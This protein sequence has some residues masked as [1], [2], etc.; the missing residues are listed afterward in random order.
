MI[1]KRIVFSCFL[2]VI[3]LT[4]V[5]FV[6]SITVGAFEF[7]TF[8]NEE[9]DALISNIQIETLQSA[10][11]KQ[12]IKCFNVNDSG[13]IA[14][15]TSDFEQKTICIYDPNGEFQYGYRFYTAGSFG[16][17][18]SKDNNDL[19]IYFVRGNLMARVTPDGDVVE[20]KKILNTSANNSYWR[21]SVNTT[22][23]SVGECQYIIK[24]DIGFFDFFTSSYSQLIIVESDGSTSII[25]DVNQNQ[26]LMIM[27]AAL[28][29]FIVMILLFIQKKTHF[30]FNTK[31]YL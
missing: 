15:G 14:I 26:L 5:F 20:F 24:N 7:D 21:N 2:F 16:I 18:W 13:M 25:Y 6:M 3:T 8:S 27:I 11:L 22:E 4:S 12:T 19:L 30:F 9:I 17:E 10:P 23:R 28:L 31:N 29:L 1:R